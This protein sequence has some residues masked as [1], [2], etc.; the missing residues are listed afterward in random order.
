MGLP[1]TIHVCLTISHLDKEE[2]GNE[3][4]LPALQFKLFYGPQ[5]FWR[6]HG[7]ELK[8]HMKD[9]RGQPHYT[10]PASFKPS[11]PCQRVQC[12]GCPRGADTRLPSNSPGSSQA[13]L[14]GFGG[15]YC[16]SEST[17]VVVQYRNMRTPCHSG[18]AVLAI[19]SQP[20]YA[21]A[22][23]DTYSSSGD[24][25]VVETEPESAACEASAFPTRLSPAWKISLQNKLHFCTLLNTTIWSTSQIFTISSNML[26]RIFDIY[27]WLYIYHYLHPIYTSYI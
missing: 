27:I 21:G 23:M 20:S 15:S 22:F 10:K 16:W 14:L 25:M 9:K 4:L 12:W 7:V 11:H 17:G 1:T 26:C 19:L 5:V 18:P 8:W 3:P 2:N 24:Y 13:V 6:S